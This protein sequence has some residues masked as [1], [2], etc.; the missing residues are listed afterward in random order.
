MYC[1]SPE[2]LA[3]C[4]P[5]CVQGPYKSARDAAFRGK[6]TYRY[7]RKPVFPP[8]DWDGSPAVRS[9]HKPKASLEP[10]RH[11]GLGIARAALT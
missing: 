11:T 8:S 3:C 9:A 7:C 4:I 2:P 10:A 1:T 6:I 5:D